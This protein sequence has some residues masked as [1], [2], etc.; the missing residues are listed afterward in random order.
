MRACWDGGACPWTPRPP[1][2]TGKRPA[3]AADDASLP[4]P[5]AGD[6]SARFKEIIKEFVGFK[7]LTGFTAAEKASLKGSADFIG[8]N[9][10]TS[11]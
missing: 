3:L 4:R 8:L 9:F 5:A 2:A 10:Y 7:E 11:K 6:Y 1:N